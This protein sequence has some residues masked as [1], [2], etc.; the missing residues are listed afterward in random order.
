VLT[1]STAE[2]PTINLGVPYIAER[3]TVD[4]ALTVEAG[5]E[6]LFESGAKLRVSSD[7]T[8]KAVGTAEQPILFSSTD[9]TPGFWDGVEFFYSAGANE[10][11]HVIVEYGGAGTNG[12]NLA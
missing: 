6:F 7:A 3:I 2:T 5:A 1:V 10:L 8:L 12:A 4:N 9:Q 11:A